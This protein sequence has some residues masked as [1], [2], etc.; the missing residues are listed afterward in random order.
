MKKKS[1]ILNEFLKTSFGRWD[2]RAVSVVLSTNRVSVNVR[3]FEGE[4]DKVLNDDLVSKGRGPPMLIL[5]G[6]LRTDCDYAK[7]FLGKNQWIR[8]GV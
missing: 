1:E 7:D 2:S 8:Y 3:I 5:I 4:R 6:N